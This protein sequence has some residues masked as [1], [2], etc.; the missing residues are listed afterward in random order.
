MSEDPHHPSDTQILEATGP[1]PFI[2]RRVYRLRDRRQRI[3]QAREHRKKL[4]RAGA[5]K[6]LG[7]SK[8]IVLCLWNPRQL[9]WWIGLIFALG[10]ALFML[11]SL[12]FLAPELAR[13]WSLDANAIN[14]IFFAG[15]IP[16][17]TAAYLQ[18]FQAANAGEFSFGETVSARPTIFFGW[19]P[20]NIGWLS[21]VL[22]FAGT[23]LFNLNT[24]DAMHPGLNWLQED[25]AVW[26]PNFL[27]S[28]LFL[29]SGHLAFAEA[30]HSFLSW[31]PGGISWW[32]TFVNLLGC[33][34][35]MISA[36]FAFVPPTPF[37]FEA[38]MVSVFFTAIGAAG[39]LIG[40][41][42]MLPETAASAG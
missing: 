30:G 4:A 26:V 2:T 3:W 37:S 22:Q 32:V 8:L 11:G 40:S 39:F 20:K 6:L 16:F 5:I 17:T 38:G 14:A 31:D 18:L 9:N 41:L 27:G 36:V 23:L 13:D 29:A 7:F 1:G 33:L 25:M 10:A 28:V 12:L 34:A 15:S 35:F 24:F 42:L 21:C 19:Q